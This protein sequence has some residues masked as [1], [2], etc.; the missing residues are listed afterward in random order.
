MY[1]RSNF[2]VEVSDCCNS[3]LRDKLSSNCTSTLQGQDTTATTV[4]YTLYLLGLHKDA[5]AR[6]LKEIDETF[7]EDSLRPVTQDDLRKLKYIEASAKVS[8]HK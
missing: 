1:Y 5:E 3:S 6:A 2:I 7:G 4:A 8:D